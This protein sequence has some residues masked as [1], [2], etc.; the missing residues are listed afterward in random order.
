[1]PKI[2]STA[3]V[4][5]GAELADDVQIEPYA[6]VGRGVTIGAGTTVRPH[7]IIHGSTLI[8][9]HCD[10][11]PAAYVGLDPQHLVF[12]KRPLEERQQTWL[13]V[14]DHVIIREGASLHRAIKPGRENATRVGNRCMIMGG[15]HVG[16]DCV[17]EDEVVMANDAL[18]GGHVQVGSRAF[19]GGGC[20]VH[21]FVRIGRIAM[22][23]GNQPVGQDVPP[24]S[25]LLYG[26]LK[27][28][29]AVGCRRAGMSQ[30]TVKSIRAAY[31]C[32][33]TNRSAQAVFAAMS[34]LELDT[35]E[36]DEIRQFMLTTKRGLMRSV[37]FLDFTRTAEEETE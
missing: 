2:H 23:G 11:G 12:L 28:Y 35:P 14:G 29:N 27:G 7:C 15:A 36:V 24:F 17:V 13:V 21:Q 32:V 34:A 22:V 33:H 3:I 30:E 20:I 4:D 19:L 31:H 37:R 6:I 1:M 18:L 8:G 26:G 9:A 10:I 25:A 5:R 16:H